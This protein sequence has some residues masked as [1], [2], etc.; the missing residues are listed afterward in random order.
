MKDKT[1]NLVLYTLG[2]LIT[3]VFIGLI[4]KDFIELYDNPSIPDINSPIHEF[5]QNNLKCLTAAK[6]DYL[7][8]DYA[9]CMYL[10]I[11]KQCSCINY[12][13]NPCIEYR[14]TDLSK[15]C[16]KY[17]YSYDELNQLGDNDIIYFEQRI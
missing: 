11:S 2:I 10:T 13:N 4:T 3:G 8:T 15:S 17:K 12:I 7:F 16:I 6:I 14:E 5:E 1:F 9:S